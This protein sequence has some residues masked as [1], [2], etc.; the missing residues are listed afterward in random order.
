MKFFKLSDYNKGL[1]ASLGLHG[2]LIFALFF[3]NDPIKSSAAA[4]PQAMSI[5]L[6]SFKPVTDA[7][8][9]AQTPPT[10]APKKIVEKVPEKKVC[11]TKPKQKQHKKHAKKHHKE[12]KK[13]KKEAPKKEYVTKE[14]VEKETPKPVDEIAK[15]EPVTEPLIE[16]AIEPQE[17]PQELA[18]KTPNTEPTEQKEEQKQETLAEATPTETKTEAQPSAATLEQE[19][20]ET[21]FEV[22]RSMVL[23]NLKYPRL[24]K[25]MQQTGIVELLL[26]IDEQ[27]K[28]IDISLENSSG[29]KLLDKSALKAAEYLAEMTLPVPKSTSKILLP[30]AFA[31]N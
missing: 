30:V 10:P 17:A 27:G 3:Y 1:I 5:S 22:I 13:Y 18:Q 12:H 19:F 4:Q 16:K 9:P 24:A 20:I 21:N 29:Y 25:R 15:A 23:E 26:V 6:S 7:P 8:K 14:P 28:L 31:L 2:L 11:K